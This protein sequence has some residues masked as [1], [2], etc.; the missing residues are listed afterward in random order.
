MAMSELWL[1]KALVCLFL[2]LPLF[3]PLVKTLWPLD[4]LVWLPLVAMIITVGIF[5][6]Y[7][8]RPECLPILLFAFI[9]TSANLDSISSSIRSQPSDA[10]HDR[11]PLLTVF[12]FITLG[13]AIFTMFAF[14]PRTGSYPETETARAL[15][16]PGPGRVY[17][18]QIYGQP[19]SGQ[20]GS[21][22]I[23]SGQIGRPIIFLVPPELGSSASIR[24]ICSE[25]ENK[26]YTVVTYSRK[27]FDLPFIDEN[28]KK[29]FSMLLQMP[30]YL[31]ASLMGARF[32]SAN[33]RGKAME[34]E[35]RADIEYLLPRI[36]GL[37]GETDY[38][39]ILLAGYGAGGSAL[40]YLNENGGFGSN[41]NVLGI[42]AVESRLWSSYETEASAV[43]KD[44]STRGFSYRILTEVVDR[45]T[46]L[47]PK[48]L[49][50]TKALLPSA[51]LPV[52]YLISGKALNYPLVDYGKGKNPY[53]AI[54]DTG[55]FASGPIAIAAIKDSGPLD[56]QDFP[57]THPVYS[58]S[59]P[60]QLNDAVN[61]ISDT[62][63]IIGNFASLLIE[64]SMPTEQVE[65]VEQAE[66]DDD[67]QQPVTLIPF[68]SQING[69][70]YIE[71]RAMPWLK[72]N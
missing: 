47:L 2:V 11:S 53:Q 69:S 1:P 70:L 39:P 45:L 52:L 63:S 4:G 16:V 10:F 8:F 61:A 71:S 12:A 64:Q 36:Y 59:L 48:T 35:R 7:G 26:G 50:R 28:G 38:E 17:Y 66:P 25:L 33:D 58:F 60:G 68:R 5:P 62:A 56:Y 9:Y 32:A 72:L 46:N 51:N 57:L 19:G 15:K 41:N 29:H 34:A 37:T 31:Y 54:F 24:L 42:I 23:G 27:D 30:G 21:D 44:S 3:R 22:Q 55:R 43:Y 13:A 14:S 67:P 40:A 6:A 65:Q 49:K 20:I 18:M